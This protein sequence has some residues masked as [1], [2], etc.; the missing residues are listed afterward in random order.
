M[1]RTMSRRGFTL[2]ELLVV[3]AIIAVLLGLLLP[4]VQKVRE[5]AA[6]LQSKN[7]LKQIALAIHNYADT[8]GGRLPLIDCNQ[9]ART[10]ARPPRFVPTPHMAAARY[11][12]A[13]AP[14]NLYGYPN[15][16]VRTLVSPADPSLALRLSPIHGWS[17]SPTGEPISL[18]QSNDP[19]TSYSAN[20]F[21]FINRADLNASFPDG[22]S[23]TIWFAERYAQCWGTASNYENFISNRATFAD[24]G[25]ILNDDNNQ[26]VFSNQHVYPITSGFPPVARP[27]RAGATFQVRPRIGNPNP[28]PYEQR[29][30]DDCD[31]AV[32]Q[33]PHASGM[34]LALGDG[35]VRSVA[36]SVQPSVFWALVTPAGGEVVGGW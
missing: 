35:A 6:R 29:E 36:P 19:A 16:F 12:E 2:L 13:S 24:G 10:S 34:L 1:V 28:D 32:P 9:S 31:F 30:P 4:A 27:S 17:Q 5:A 23:Q 11:A 26:N 33:T 22:L 8:E 3:I 14:R 21:A 18:D 7:N 20:A 25:P 15:G